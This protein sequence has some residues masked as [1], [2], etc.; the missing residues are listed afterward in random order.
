MKKL[1]KRL[2]IKNLWNTDRG[3]VFHELSMTDLKNRRPF[4]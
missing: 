3:L 1:L 4:D 2:N